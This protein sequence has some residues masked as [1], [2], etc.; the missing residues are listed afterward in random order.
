MWTGEYVL[1]FNE[2]LARRPCKPSSNKGDEGED[3]DEDP[4]RPVFSLVT[5]KYR[6]ARRYGGERLSH[7]P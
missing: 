7:A 3:E 4:D 1:D 5:G 2:V 6:H